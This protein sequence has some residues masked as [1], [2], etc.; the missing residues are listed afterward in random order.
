LPPASIVLDEL[1]DLQNKMHKPSEMLEHPFSNCSHIPGNI[2]RT[3]MTRIK[4]IFTASQNPP[5][6]RG[7][8]V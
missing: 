4:W 2:F 1:L 8:F 6:N 7:A 3:R 5:E